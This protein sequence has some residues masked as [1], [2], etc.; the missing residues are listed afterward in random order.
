MNLLSSSCAQLF[1]HCQDAVIV[2]TQTYDVIYVNDQAN[3]LFQRDFSLLWEKHPEPHRQLFYD[4]T[5]SP[6]ATIDLPLKQVN[7]GIKITDLE[8]FLPALALGSGRWLLF[9]GFPLMVD[10]VS[11][12]SGAV[13]MVQ[14]ITER[15]V[16]EAVV[17]T[18]SL[19]DGLTSLLQRNVFIDRVEHALAR[20]EHHVSG[21]IA[22]VYIDI[23]H[24]KLV[25]DAFGHDIGDLL[26][27]EFAHRLTA[28][29]RSEDTVSRLGGDTFAILLEDIASYSTVVTTIEQLY[30]KLD[31]PF[32]LAEQP[33]PIDASMGIALGD[34]NARHPE[35]L[36][37][38]ARIAMY[39][40]K[41]TAGQRY[42]LF[43]DKMQ[44]HIEGDLRLEIALRKAI[45]NQEL[46]L[47][48]QP[49]VLI[50]SKETI[51]FEALVRWQHPKQGLLSPEKFIHIAE[52]TGLIVPLGWW[53]LREACYQLRAW[54][55][56]TPEAKNLFVSVN[57][58]SKQFFQ[59]DAADRIAK[60]LD[61]THLSGENLK[62]EI[63]ESVLIENSTSIV[64]QL[65]SIRNLG[66][67][68][69]IDDFGTGYSSLSYLYQFPFDTLKI[70]RSF[71]EGADTSYDKLEILQSVVRLAWNLGLEVVAEGVE[72][73]KH[74]S[75][76]KALRC[77]SGQGYLFS[78]P[79][80]AT[81]METLIHRQFAG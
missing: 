42:C 55:N 81:A 52:K 37:R 20:L 29:L 12:Q 44:T 16:H 19:R 3:T 32:M 58:S 41:K 75:Q 72:T 9:N 15:K 11:R 74:H 79:L 69:S 39:Q 23:N 80:T 36:L 57:M 78:R 22:L 61:D 27:V 60:I 49:I 5:T 46:V 21:L 30:E 24:L 2:V 66:I 48:Y 17:H 43:E 54:Q 31:Q 33:I 71:I 50:R 8:L 26:L 18:N 28:A 38:A 64:Q 34:T 56:N 13:V 73:P 59:G 67:K 53:V 47:H 63:T 1:D 6:V 70:D 45:P 10:T 25:N 76:L 14:D 40:A 68:L 62:I 4:D 51:G 65:T 7:A 35:D 77:E